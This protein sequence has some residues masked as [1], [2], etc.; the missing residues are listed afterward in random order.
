MGVGER[1]KV[2]RGG[3]RGEDVQWEGGGGVKRTGGRRSIGMRER[4]GDLFK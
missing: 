2:G 4:G 1:E 3:G